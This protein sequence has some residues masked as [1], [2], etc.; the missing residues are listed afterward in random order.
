MKKALSTKHIKVTLWLSFILLICLCLGALNYF[1]QQSRQLLGSNFTALGIDIMQAQED[2]HLLN[3]SLNYLKKDSPF[4]DIKALDRLAIRLQYRLPLIQRKIS[5]SVL[6]KRDYST[7]LATLKKVQNIT[8]AEFKENLQEYKQKPNGRAKLV[9]SLSNL[10]LNLAVAYSQLHNVIQAA[11]D[12]ERRIK[13]KLTLLIWSLIIT[14]LL[15][16]FALLVALTRLYDTKEILTIQNNRDHL[17]KL[18]N[19]RCITEEIE[20]TLL[21][22]P[23]NIGFAILDLDWFK[24]VNDLYG[25]PAGDEV[26]KEVAK[27]L[28]AKNHTPNTIARLGGEEFCILFIDQSKD[29]VIRRCEDIRQSIAQARITVNKSISIHITISIGLYYHEDQQKTTFSQIYHHADKALYMA[30]KLGR[31]QTHLHKDETEKEQKHIA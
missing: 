17:T 29:E 15:V 26:L 13:S 8:L 21:K 2:V 20:A 31:N 12:I 28:A 18:P 19:R 14:I 27:L 23:S 3:V 11:S 24:K 1:Q 30:K 7:S 9:L 6:E 25:H 4:F 5:Q 16:L 22:Q 10:E